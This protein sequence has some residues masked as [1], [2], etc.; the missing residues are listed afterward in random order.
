MKSLKIYCII[1]GLFLTLPAFSQ[2]DIIATYDGGT[3]TV[4]NIREYMI[5][6]KDYRKSMVYGYPNKAKRDPVVARKMAYDRLLAKMA[7]KTGYDK[8]STV[9]AKLNDVKKDLLK[10]FYIQRTIVDKIQV[11][12][13]EVQNRYQEK[14]KTTFTLP[15]QWTFRYLFID[16][17][18]WDTDSANPGTYSR[19]THIFSLVE[20]STSF[21]ELAKQ[22]SDSEKAK[23]NGGLVGPMEIGNL[24][25]AIVST[26]HTLSPGQ[27]SGLFKI[28]IGYQIL[29]LVNYTP[30]SIMPFENVKR[31][32]K[33]NMQSE[34]TEQAVNAFMNKIISE[35]SIQRHFDQLTKPEIPP[36]T[37]I[38]ESKMTTLRY[39][40]VESLVK[41]HFPRRFKIS[42]N[43]IED[44]LN[45]YV[46]REPIAQMALQAGIQNDP[47]YI[48][49]LNL[50]RGDVYASC[51]ELEEVNKNIHP[52][53]ADYREY[54]KIH[55]R[56]YTSSLEYLCREIRVPVVSGNNLNPAQAKDAA[57]HKAEE[58]RQRIIKG[59]K[60]EDLAKQYST[61][62]TA[63][64][65]GQLDWINQFEGGTIY[66]QALQN[67]KPGEMSKPIPGPKYVLLLQ[68]QKTRVP[69]I[70]PYDSIA[71]KLKRDYTFMRVGQEVNKLEEKLLKQAHF[72]IVEKPIPSP[73]P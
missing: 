38:I 73:S 62:L 24:N 4:D 16:S 52:T 26:L 9:Q 53:E 21:S 5:E 27:V 71:F 29:Q 57:L 3:I 47:E 17:R 65:G 50:H 34:K 55:G 70:P 40:D 14:L 31:D 39:S 67:L 44:I 51:M 49:L 43:E 48:R 45:E 37:I 8:S 35:Q 42:P 68:L 28:P 72:K 11:T 41:M 66:Y 25:P 32:I 2:Q 69:E 33:D 61:G 6:F 1:I 7:E 22:Y 54:Y 20:K 59:E 12:D 10:Q 46:I 58:L 15:E 64:N 18:K 36:D 19:A 13:A 56:Q 63:K 60:F 23:E 30:S